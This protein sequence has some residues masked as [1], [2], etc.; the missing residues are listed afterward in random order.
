MFTGHFVFYRNMFGICM[1]AALFVINFSLSTSHVLASS[2]HN[3]MLI[4]DGSISMGG[5]IERKSKISLVKKALEPTLKLVRSR[6]QL[7][8]ITYGNRRG[9]CDDIE[10]TVKLG[11]I[12]PK[13]YMKTID[14]I[15]AK[16]RTPIVKAVRMAAEVLKKR[17]GQFN[18]IILVTDGFDACNKNLAALGR[19]L[20]N[21]N[22]G[23]KIYVIALRSSD[24]EMTSLRQLAART[25]G[26]YIA[27]NTP[28][29]IRQTIDQVFVTASGGGVPVP[30][31]GPRRMARD[32]SEAR[33]KNAPLAEKPSTDIKPEETDASILEAFFGLGKKIPKIPAPPPL[34][35]DIPKQEQPAETSTAPQTPEEQSD[36][37]SDTGNLEVTSVAAIGGAVINGATY[38][39][40][41]AQ[42]GVS[43]KF[44]EISRSSNNR[45]TF[46]LPAGTY[47]LKVQS[48]LASIERT[49]KI[50][51]NKTKALVLN[52]N[53]GFLKLFARPA[54]GAEI[55]QD[56][57]HYAIY[58]GAVS[59]EGKRQQIAQ[60][61]QSSPA[62]WLSTG[63]YFITATYGLASANMEVKITANRRTEKTIIVNAGALRLSS[64][65]DGL[66]EKL[67]SQILYVIYDAKADT[68]G[69]Y[70]EVF[71][72]AQAEGIVRVPPGEYLIEGHWGKTNAKV[73]M[74]AVVKAGEPTSATVV[75]RAGRAR[76][77]L[78]SVSGGT[79]TGR[80]YWTFYDISGA[81]IGRDAKP[82]PERIFAAGRY[83]VVVRYQNQ[84]FR[85]EFSIKSGDQKRIDIVA[86]Q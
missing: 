56:K 64:K 68:E 63:N 32:A 80:P 75:H 3:A 13:R 48:D 58:K 79:P 1:F 65:I 20:K 41:Q 33:T 49:V 78:K 38:I 52:L 9:G 31:V 23:L 7:G 59:L 85:A 44:T 47:R 69:N 86:T 34:P 15:G 61:T 19:D 36:P 82:S 21:E 45:P 71:S 66:P 37:G 14:A 26:K 35:A 46:T 40:L 83:I 25:G 18:S 60:L 8:V 5:R 6:L 76:F 24:A 39:V 84:R 51:A 53:A 27:A 57:V 43:G 11:A 42:D 12:S 4:I 54:I 22:L 67:T 50:E 77:K 73:P 28:K 74:S 55:L 81:E 17:R 16:G 62:L 29:A 72:T 70:R 30:Q 2:R 10:L